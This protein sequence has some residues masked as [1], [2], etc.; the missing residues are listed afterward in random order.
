MLGVDLGL[1]GVVVRNAEM[2]PLL[3]DFID[4]P[5][6]VNGV[7]AASF[8]G[9]TGAS[10]ARSGS[11]TA[12]TLAGG[13]VSFGAGVQRITDQGLFLEALGTNLLGHSS[14]SGGS[15]YL[16][17][18]S[19]TAGLDD[20]AGGMDGTRLN[21][22]AAADAQCYCVP[23]IAA[24]VHTISVFARAVS[25]TKTFR[26]AYYDGS[27]TLASSDF[28]A[29]TTWRR[30]S[31]VFTGT[32]AGGEALSIVNGTSGVAG[33]V[34]VALAQ[35]ESGPVAT[36]PIVTAGGP[37][38]RAAD[39]ASVTVPAGV[40]AWS[41]VFGEAGTVVTGTVTPGASFDLVAGRPWLNV[42]LKRLTM[43]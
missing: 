2:L 18:P 26:L 9:L 30:F 17:G 8:V 27:S 25:G 3:I 35:V 7:A 34:I 28:T 31:F 16:A 12:T 14:V 33:E 43:R 13:V 38:T 42:G 37:T 39:V 32:G 6:Q 21:F 36:S 23:S 41:A 19:R 10:F 20:P 29:T 15:W 5:Y 40:S 24:A 11:G 22:P 4:G 1:S